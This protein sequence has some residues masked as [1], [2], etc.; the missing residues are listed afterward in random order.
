MD[1]NKRARTVRDGPRSGPYMVPRVGWS[2]APKARSGRARARTR[3]PW[4]ATSA[5]VSRTMPVLCIYSPT[6]FEPEICEFARASRRLTPPHRREM[7]VYY[8]T[9]CEAGTRP[10][11]YTSSWSLLRI[12]RTLSVH[13]QHVSKCDIYFCEL[14]GLVCAHRGRPQLRGE[15]SVGITC[16]RNGLV[17]YSRVDLSFGL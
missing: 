3:L 4:R 1:D 6:N 16:G 5:R 12:S 9:I 11:M 13:Y 7:G 17:T 10:R 8:T 15:A 14:V 2:R